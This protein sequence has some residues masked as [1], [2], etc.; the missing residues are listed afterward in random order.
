MTQTGKALKGRVPPNVLLLIVFICFLMGVN[1]SVMK[2]SNLF[3]APMV[4]VFL[5]VLIAAV[6]IAL[7]MAWSDRSLLLPAPG[8]R[9]KVLRQS[10]LFSGHVITMYLSVHYIASGR[11][12]MICYTVPFFA[13]LFERVF[14]GV[15]PTA[16]QVIGMCIAFAGIVILFTDRP[17]DVPPG[18]SLLGDVLIVISAMCWA[19][20]SV[21]MKKH[22]AAVTRP[23][24]TVL[25]SAAICCLLALVIALL[26][27]D[28]ATARVT[29][30]FVLLVL[31]QGVLVAFV[32]FTIMQALIYRYSA[33]LIHTFTFLPPL[34]GV[35][36]GVLFL[37][38]PAGVIMAICLAM[39]CCGLVLVN[40]PQHK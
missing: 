6:C 24:Q 3:A 12:A 1:W 39:V 23:H 34:F 40:S 17:G 4:V 30:N 38:E 16:K 35:L 26:R 10:L 9:L 14:L 37:G 13:V 21:Y 32:A 28:F 36:S 8:L 25:W 2:A 31:Y 19:G 20:S 15:K 11:S 27:G 33:G 7:W 5:R 22:L 29:T 18:A